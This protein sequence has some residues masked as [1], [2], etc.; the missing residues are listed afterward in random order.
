MRKGKDIESDG[1]R[2]EFLILEVML[3]IRDLLIKQ[4]KTPNKKKKECVK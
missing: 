1:K 3:D 2:P 4:S